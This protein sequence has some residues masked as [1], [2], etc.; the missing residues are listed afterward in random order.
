MT[1]IILNLPCPLC[2]DRMLKAVYEPQ[3]PSETPLLAQ[4]SGCPHADQVM[5]ELE[6]HPPVNLAE[7]LVLWR[8]LNHEAEMYCLDR[9]T[10]LLEASGKYYRRLRGEP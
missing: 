10:D 7:S 2:Q 3:L 1:D 6:G 5:M 4:V 8:T 9:Y